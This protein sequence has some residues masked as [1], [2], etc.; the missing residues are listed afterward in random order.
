MRLNELWTCPPDGDARTQARP[1][2]VNVVVVGPFEEE[3]GT[4]VTSDVV[5]VKGE[6]P[7]APGPLKR[8]DPGTVTIPQSYRVNKTK[9]LTLG[10][11]LSFFLECTVWFPG[12]QGFRYVRTPRNPRKPD[13]LGP[14]GSR[15]GWSEPG[16]FNPCG[17]QGFWGVRTYRKPGKPGNQN[18]HSNREKCKKKFYTKGLDNSLFMVRMWIAII[19]CFDFSHV[20]IQ[21]SCIHIYISLS[22]L[23][24]LNARYMIKTIYTWK[25]NVTWVHVQNGNDFYECYLEHHTTNTVLCFFMCLGYYCGYFIVVFL[26]MLMFIFSVQFVYISLFLSFF[27]WFGRPKLIRVTGLSGCW[28]PD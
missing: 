10:I 17:F 23:F 26:C 19:I 4:S 21:F 3:E 28:T 27:L 11:F 25:D 6:F 16:R 14:S 1:L 18:R 20:C 13:G 24:V 5:K 22:S 9:Q 7:A 15:T 12:F 2:V 8:N